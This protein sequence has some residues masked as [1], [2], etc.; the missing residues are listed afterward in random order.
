MSVELLKAII[1]TILYMAAIEI[2]AV[3][4][5]IPEWL[6][7]DYMKWYW[8]IQGI[9]QL[10]I[11]LLFVAVVNRQDR[12]V[13]IRRCRH[14]ADFFHK[15]VSCVSSLSFSLISN[16]SLELAEDLKYHPFEGLFFCLI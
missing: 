7:L 2:V 1:A 14:L 15:L 4:T 9:C 16:D 10:G 8:L 3:W 12:Y 11:V 13:I 6:E 5:F